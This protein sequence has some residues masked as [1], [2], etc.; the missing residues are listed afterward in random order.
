MSLG[1]LILAALTLGPFGY[2]LGW[3]LGY[4]WFGTPSLPG[5]IGASV[6][7]LG[8]ALSN[9]STSDL[10]RKSPDEEI[11]LDENYTLGG[12]RFNRYGDDD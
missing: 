4:L 12:Q 7:A 2:G 9:A 8:G 11:C 5:V 1:K 10:P 3:L 6:F